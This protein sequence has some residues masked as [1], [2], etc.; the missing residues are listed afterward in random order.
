[1]IVLLIKPYISACSLSP[2]PSK[3]RAGILITMPLLELQDGSGIGKNHDVTR[4][5]PPRTR[6]FLGHKALNF[7]SSLADLFFLFGVHLDFF[8]FKRARYK[9]K[10]KV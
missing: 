8:F 2:V 4:L 6:G 5:L 10:Y 3:I 7:N 1:M 9:K